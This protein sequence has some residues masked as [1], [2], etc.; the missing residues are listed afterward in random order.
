M[1]PGGVFAFSINDGDLAGGVANAE[2]MF[3]CYTPGSM[4]ISI[5]QMIGFSLE[6]RHELDRAVTWIELQRPGEKSSL[7]A[8]QALAKVIHKPRPLAPKVGI[9]KPTETVVDTQTPKTY[10]TEERE[11]LIQRAI[12]LNIDTPERLRNDYSIKQLRKTIKQ[13]NPR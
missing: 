2:R 3:M 13:R 7:R 10:N 1:R 9:T 8:G 4:I 12:D 6:L 5:S 11:M